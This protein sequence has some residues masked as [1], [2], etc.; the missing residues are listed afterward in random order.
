MIQ[1]Q[2]LR[3]NNLVLVNSKTPGKVT[4]IYEDRAQV[5]YTAISETTGQSYTKRSYI[6]GHWLEGIPLTSEWLER[7]GYTQEYGSNYKGNIGALY[8]QARYYSGILYLDAPNGLYLDDRIKFV[9][10]YQ[11]LYHALTGNELT[12]T[13]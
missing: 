13:K 5:E 8:V 3:L 11:N 7:M 6:D 12:W 9:H 1:P 10:E 4:R 2:E